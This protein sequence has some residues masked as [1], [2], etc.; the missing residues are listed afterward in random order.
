MDEKV[1]RITREE[2]RLPDMMDQI[3]QKLDCEVYYEGFKGLKKKVH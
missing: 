3:V 1:L 2:D